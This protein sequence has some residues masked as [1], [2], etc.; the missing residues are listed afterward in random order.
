MDS[1][2]PARVVCEY[3]DRLVV[4]PPV[5]TPVFG[6]LAQRAMSFFSFTS[7]RFSTRYMVGL[8]CFAY[9]VH[10]DHYGG[11]CAVTAV[12]LI[13]NKLGPDIMSTLLTVMAI[14]MGSVFGAQFFTYSCH[15]GLGERPL[16][17]ATALY[18]FGGLFIYFGGRCPG[19]A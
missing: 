4:A 1:G 5:G 19:P 2:L 12:F 13:H 11:A 3:V 9:T 8:L 7:P 14:V 6:A 18:L 10:M 15:A 17:L 16:I